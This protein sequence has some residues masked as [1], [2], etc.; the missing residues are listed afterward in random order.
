VAELQELQT[1]L[2]KAKEEQ[3]ALRRERDQVGARRRRA[4]PVGCLRAASAAPPPRPRL[5]R[6]G[7]P[8][9]ARR[10]QALKDKAAA[11][12]EVC[13]GKYRILHLTT[14]LREADAKAAART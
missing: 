3:D 11:E 6:S 4:L 10:L 14:A 12:K 8:L 1:L 9:P 5:R 13:K 2:L 7:T